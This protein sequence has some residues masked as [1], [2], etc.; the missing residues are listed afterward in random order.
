MYRAGFGR[1]DMTVYEPGMVMQGW[2][3]QDN[4]ITGIGT[5]LFARAL[6]VEHDGP[7]NQKLAFVCADLN[8][9][10][11]AL[12]A[13]VI[14]ALGR[15]HAGRGLGAHN[16]MLTATHT[17]SGPSGYSQY[18]MY[19]A[20]NFGFSPYVWSG[21]VDAIVAAIAAA[22]DALEPATLRLGEAE[23]PE[24]EPVGFNRSIASYLRNGDVSSDATVTSAV[25]RR[26]VTLRVDRTVGGETLGIVNWLGVHASNVHGDQTLLHG[27]NKGLAALQMER[28]ARDDPGFA[29]GFVAI[30]AQAAAGDVQPNFRVDA[31]RGLLVGAHDEDH[32]SAAANAAIQV[33]WARV[34][35]IAAR[36]SAP[37]AGRIRV[38]TMTADL[39]AVEVDADLAGRR[40]VRTQ[41]AQLGLGQAAGNPEGPG[42][43]LRAAGLLRGYASLHR[44]LVPRGDAK[45]HFLEVG[46]GLEGRVLG[47]LPTR[48][49]MPFVARF[50]P[51]IAFLHAADQAGELAAGPWVPN[52]LPLQLAELGDLAILALPVE[53]TVTAARRLRATVATELAARPPRM[54]VIQGYANA[55]AG[56]LCTHEEY[57]RQAYE[58]G[59]TYFGAHSLAAWQTLVRQLARRPEGDDRTSIGPLP[60]RFDPAQLVRQRIAGRRGVRGPGSESH[61]PPAAHDAHTRAFA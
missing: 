12:R 27:D 53:L 55:Y 17:H 44:A 13:G 8:T 34:G 10:S 48:W 40:G 46:R 59:A 7:S 22:D 33:R 21:L 2:A 26:S 4:R 35:A 36:S 50:E 58:A 43:L 32:A 23:I 20:A 42:P 56:Y 15:E 24:D 6:V 19:N 5:R 51:M 31:R 54:I 1:A 30:F 47:L 16:V 25:D 61:V 18:A 28:E 29:P 9:I 57:Q 14:A 41:P 60:D 38:R 39:G 52:V 37:L 11:T 3:S 45:P 49:A